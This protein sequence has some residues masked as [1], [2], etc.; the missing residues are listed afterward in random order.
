MRVYYYRKPMLLAHVV[1]LTDDK[2]F[3]HTSQSSIHADDKILLECEIM[4]DYVR[5]Y[6]PIRI[7]ETVVLRH[8]SELDHFVKK[9]MKQYGI[10]NV[11]GGTYSNMDLT[12]TEKQFI[13][14]EH[15]TTIESM[16]N[17][18]LSMTNL[19]TEYN[20]IPTWPLERLNEEMVKTMNRQSLYD[21]ETAMLRNYSIGHNNIETTAIFLADIKWLF[22]TAAK[23]LQHPRNSIHSGKDV[24]QKYRKILDKMKALYKI[25]S[26]Y[27]DVEITYKPLIHLY[28]P[29]TILDVFFLHYHK[30]VD[31]NIHMDQFIKFLE[32]YEYIFYFIKCRIDEYTF[33][34][35]TYPPD[36]KVTNQYRIQYLQHYIDNTI[37][38]SRHTICDI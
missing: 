25:F 16:S 33:D 32:Y 8:D 11:R 10:E 7:L 34:V 1:L 12:D 18:W 36:F 2:L 17:R 35:N 38:D 19:F 9:Y 23:N 24:T 29:E 13:M 6:K 30:I 5:K 37:S 3:F 26:T 21:N 27:G 14:R 31:L 22:N 15:A 28:A 20:D 4:Y